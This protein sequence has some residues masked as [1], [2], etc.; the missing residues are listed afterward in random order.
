MNFSGW[1]GDLCCRRLL[2]MNGSRINII[3]LISLG[4]SVHCSFEWGAGCGSACCWMFSMT[5]SIDT[6]PFSRFFAPSRFGLRTLTGTDIWTDSRAAWGSEQSRLVS[7]T[8]FFFFGGKGLPLTLHFALTL[9]F[10][11]IGAE[12]TC[13]VSAQWQR[14][15]RY[16]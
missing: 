4:T 2:I 9:A 5:G 12:R 13:Q 11:A 14:Q 6:L 10:L 8:D 15:G 16:Q 3:Y 1:T 7:R